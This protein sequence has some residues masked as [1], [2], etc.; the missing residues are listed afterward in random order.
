MVVVSD[1]WIGTNDILAA[2]D[3]YDGAASVGDIA[4]RVGRSETGV[5]NHVRALVERGDLV[6]LGYTSSGARCYGHPKAKP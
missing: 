1:Q 5:R 6:P 2:V 3:Y 4:V